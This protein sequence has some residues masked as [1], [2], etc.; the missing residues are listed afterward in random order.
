MDITFA[1][2]STVVR[3]RCRVG[4]IISPPDPSAGIMGEHI[5]SLRVFFG[6]Q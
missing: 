3:R 2:D 5:S 1:F 6:V 4:A